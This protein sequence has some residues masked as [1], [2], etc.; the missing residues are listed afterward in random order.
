MPNYTWVNAGI[1]GFNRKQ[2]GVHFSVHTLLPVK[3]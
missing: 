3:M 2:Q 1:P